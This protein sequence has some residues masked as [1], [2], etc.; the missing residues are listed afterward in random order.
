MAANYAV[1]KEAINE[2]VY[3][4]MAEIAKAPIITPAITGYHETGAYP[5]DPEKA[6]QL[7][8]ES[9]WVD[10]DGD[11]IRE[12][13]WGTR[14]GRELA[15][16]YYFPVGRYEGS[17]DMALM[18]QDYLTAVGFSITLQ[19]VEPAMLVEKFAVIAEELECEMY[20]FSFTTV[21]GDAHFTMDFG[22]LTDSWVPNCCNRPYFSDMEV[23]DWIYKGHE[24]PALEERNEW[25][26]K[27]LDKIFRLAPYIQ[28][29]VTP[30][31]VAY[32]DGVHGIAINPV[33]LIFPAYFAWKEK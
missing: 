27:A 3:Y 2:T 13:V 20:N 17:A 4:G 15:V 9:G 24:S 22:F 14:G 21:T 19:G 5:Y 12:D 32:R 10:I 6:K 30:A 29:I 1:D 7:L 28:L 31:T 26:A 16:L 23:D 25:Y 18:I 11:G 8:E 33:Q